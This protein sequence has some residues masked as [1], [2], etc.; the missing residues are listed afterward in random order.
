MATTYFQR[1]L[2][3]AARSE[4]V[5]ELVDTRHCSVHPNTPLQ[6]N[7]VGL[8]LCPKPEHQPNRGDDDDE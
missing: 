2:A 7:W 6:K 4:E 8:W 5:Y 1:M 3:S